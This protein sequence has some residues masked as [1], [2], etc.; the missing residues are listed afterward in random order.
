M[1]TWS[2]IIIKNQNN[3]LIYYDAEVIQHINTTYYIPIDE[4]FKKLQNGDTEIHE[5]YKKWID[6]KKKAMKPIYPSVIHS[7]ISSPKNSTGDSATGNLYIS[8]E[9]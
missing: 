5:L 6:A 1:L 7:A 2:C 3:S 9:G 4:L 8:P